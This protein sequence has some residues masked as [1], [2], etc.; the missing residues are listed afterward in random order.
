MGKENI[1]C[2]GTSGTGKSLIMDN[3]F[4]IK[5]E[6][7][8]HIKEMRQTAWHQYY[9]EEKK[10][11]SKEHGTDD[12]LVYCIPVDPSSRFANEQPIAS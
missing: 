1:F 3:V 10:K 8:D 2:L 6:S 12:L 9:I 7:P 4:Q 5:G 11:K